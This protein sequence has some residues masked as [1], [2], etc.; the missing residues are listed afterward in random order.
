MTW[1]NPNTGKGWTDEEEATFAEIQ[2]VSRL[3]RIQAIQL[4]KRF[5][6][7]QVKAVAVAKKNYPRPTQAQLAAAAKG[8]ATQAQRRSRV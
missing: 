7:N 6:K 2:D 1:I 8:R 5:K 3:T 4:W